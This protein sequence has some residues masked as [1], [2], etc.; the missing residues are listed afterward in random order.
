MLASKAVTVEVKQY[1]APEKP[2]VEEDPEQKPNGGENQ[3]SSTASGDDKKTEVAV[4][5]GDN[6]SL[7]L[8][9]LLLLASGAVCAG[10]TLTVRKNK[11]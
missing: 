4:K 7:A 11:K 2:P 9:G 5:T 8:W 6:S 1:E 10:A 3:G